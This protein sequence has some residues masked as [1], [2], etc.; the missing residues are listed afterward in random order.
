MSPPR[1]TEDTNTVTNKH[2]H[3]TNIVTDK[4]TS[5]SNNCVDNYRFQ[6]VI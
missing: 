2:I 1:V 5:D 4:S 3:V 6:S